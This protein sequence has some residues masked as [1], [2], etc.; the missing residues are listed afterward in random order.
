MLLYYYITAKKEMTM[1]ER[2]DIGA[3]LARF[4][5]ALKQSGSGLT[6]F[7]KSQYMDKWQSETIFHVLKIRT[8][9]VN[10]MQEFLV[11]NGI[12][13][14]ERVSLS[15]VTDPLAHDIEYSPTLS[16]KGQPYKTTHSMI[17]S[18]FLACTNPYLK[19][20]Y[21][22]SPNI[23]LELESPVGEQ[24]GRYLI[25]FSQMDMEVR[26]E[27]FVPLEDYY[28][29]VEK[30]KKILKEDLGKALSFFED[31]IIYA[32]KALKEKNEADLAALGVKLEV[33]A[34]PF[35]SYFLDEAK[36]KA[37]SASVE[38]VLGKE[39]GSQFFWIKGILRENYDLVYPYL[40]ADGSKRNQDDIPSED[41]YN[42][43]L[44]AQSALLEGGMGGALEVLS[45]AI[46]EWLYEPIIARLIDNKIIP[47]EPKFDRSGEITNIEK[48]SG[49]A[50]FLSVA[51][52]KGPDGAPLFPSTFGGGIGVERLL[53][54]LLK[55][56]VIKKIDDV[57]LFGKNPDSYPV[58]IF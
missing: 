30:V 7:A 49:Y 51:S 33:P 54:A 52:M 34:K 35:P 37:A 10:A 13:N 1:Q 46:R 26:R 6:A 8:T 40:K 39:C 4:H 11:N 28:N 56:P 21:I 55:G 3:S 45:G 58:Y 43:D 14:L 18:K 23:R 22:D 48:L 16:Y 27:R 38:K 42:Y 36:K 32:V 47:E 29:E 12:L 15:P 9:L 25:D 17:Y 41:I 50:P 2:D 5:A 57:T 31:L 44:C 53:Y 20:V 19:G 24:R